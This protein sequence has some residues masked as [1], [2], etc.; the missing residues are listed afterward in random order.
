MHQGKCFFGGKIFVY[1]MECGHI[2]FECHVE[3]GSPCQF[4]HN[5]DENKACNDI[6][7][8]WVGGE[9]GVG[10][11]HVKAIGSQL[12]VFVRCRTSLSSYVL[13]FGLHIAMQ[14]Q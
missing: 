1:H 6:S 11:F 5:C 13:Q 9:G 7:G 4:C 10:C 3:Q 2:V 14:Y 12:G 8:D